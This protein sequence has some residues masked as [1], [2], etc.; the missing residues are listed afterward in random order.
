MSTTLLK[1][2]DVLR[3]LGI[4]YVTLW[5]WMRAGK[6]PTARVLSK[7]VHRWPE[8]EVERWIETNAINGPHQV[9]LGMPGHVPPAG[10]PRGRKRRLPVAQSVS[11]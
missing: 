6:F 11:A 9:L 8:A 2:E 1:K 7:N 4:S 5:S 3:R 10:K